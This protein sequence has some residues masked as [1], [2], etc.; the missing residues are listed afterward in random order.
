[1]G[2]GKCAAL[3]AVLV[4]SCGFR[5]TVPERGS[6]LES[7]VPGP[8]FRKLVRAVTG[9]LN[10][11]GAPTLRLKEELG[12]RILERYIEGW[13]PRRQLLIQADVEAT[14]RHRHIVSDDLRK[15]ELDL[16]FAL[17]RLFRARVERRVAH[18][19]LLLEQRFDFE[20][21]ESVTNGHRNI[22]WPVDHSDL[23]ERWR[24]SVKNDMIELRLAGRTS[25][26]IVG[27][28]ESR[29]LAE[30]DR[31]KKVDADDIVDQW[32]NAYVRTVDPHGAYLA[33]RTSQRLAI[34]QKGVIVG[35]GVVLGSR[36]GHAIVERVIPGSP[37]AQGGKV[38]VGDRIIGIKDRKDARFLN[39]LGWPVREVAKRLRGPR[40]SVVELQILS[41]APRE[42]SMTVRLVRDRFI[43]P[44][45]MATGRLAEP[46][47][48]EQPG[49][50]GVIDI[51]TF[52]VSADSNRD[53]VHKGSSGHIRR[54]IRTLQATGMEGLI[55]D[56][57]RN[58]GGTVLDAV[59]TAGLFL[60]GGPM[61]QIRSHTGKVTVY[62]DPDP[63][64]EW[65]GPLAVLV[66]PKSASA[67]EIVAAAIQ[68]YRRG[69]IIG[70]RTFGKGTVQKIIGLNDV[71]KGAA[72]K[73][74][75]SRWYR[76]T[77]ESVAGRGV[78]PDV[79][80][81][82]VMG[83]AHPGL[84]RPRSG[85]DRSIKGISRRLHHLTE[86]RIAIVREH[87]R[88][89]MERSPAVQ[90][91]R[92][93]A[94]E[95]VRAMTARRLSLHLE[96]RRAE[97][98]QRERRRSHRIKTL[99]RALSDDPELRNVKELWKLRNAMVLREATRITFDLATR[100]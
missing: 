57:R 61:M 72:L 17:F 15:G 96:R 16:P 45:W 71:R 73:Y 3:F 62:R 36:S 65:R 88:R 100:R 64:V 52:P 47:N 54:L 90:A 55:L 40:K 20:R 79:D 7:L 14:M 53:A 70:E 99:T 98:H 44:E 56:L 50:I 91:L 25:E 63:G 97:H 1:M 8:E 48:R 31:L 19:L 78:H 9:L 29:Y 41:A 13:D 85:R 38:H 76:V 82:R 89:R 2:L 4:V 92:E 81:T 74:S 27:M 58:A 93:D 34:R 11:H 42:T 68:D 12:T 23:R 39:V 33:P 22:K 87:S 84:R 37:A 28:L 86:R 77:G 30:R 69:I 95:Q 35:V 49:K 51:P 83:S 94:E 32:L 43:V 46:D 6:V 59:R 66:G 18:A 10:E 60:G 75:S 67:A 26:E 24:K 80:L 5:P 21:E